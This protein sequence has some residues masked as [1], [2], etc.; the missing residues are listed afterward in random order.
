MARYARPVLF[1]AFLLAVAA[2]VFAHHGAASVYNP[3]KKV[4]LK[5][6]VTKILWANPHIAIFFDAADPDTGT[7]VSWELGD[8]KVTTV[9]I[10]GHTPGSLGLIFPVKEG[11]KTHIVGIVGGGMLPQGTPDQ[12]KVFLHSLAQFEDWAKKM[13]VD[14]E[15]QNHPIMDGFADRLKALQARKP[16]EPNPF[17][18]GQENYSKFLQ[19]M[20]Q[21]VQVY[22]DRH[23]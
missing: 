4:T 21:C 20:Y 3:N 6:T 13:K 15:L 11:G 2:P 17:V 8:V 7:I 9:L 22:I 19:V 14:V 23:T 10:P 5:G 12:M 1:L 18:V 16:G